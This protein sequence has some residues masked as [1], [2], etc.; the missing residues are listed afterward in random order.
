MHSLVTYSHF[1]LIVFYIALAVWGLPE[2]IGTFVQ[3]SEKGAR[4][5][6]RGSYLVL[7]IS[8]VIAMLAA[9]YS[10]NAIPATTIAWHQPGLFWS[11]IALILAGVAF[12][13]Y[14]IRVLGRYFSRDVA[15]REGQ[16]VVDRG[17]YRLIRHPSYTGGL[18]SLLGVGLALTNWLSIVALM[19]GALIGFN[20]RVHV[21][22]QA[23]CDAIG[24]PYRD[25]MRRTWR[26]IPYVW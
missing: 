19:A 26:F 7:T 16:T 14:A 8:L 6:D 12:R 2:L 3:R 18:L 15:T 22:E 10:V 9:F 24:Q 11:G 5:H 23:L 20:Y 17:P 21:E 4:R 13:W 1:H 25:Y